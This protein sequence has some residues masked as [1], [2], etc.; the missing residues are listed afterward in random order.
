MKNKH[1]I[2]G[3]QEFV[4]WTTIGNIFAK[5]LCPNEDIL[6]QYNSLT[7]SQRIKIKQLFSQCDDIRRKKIPADEVSFTWE[8]GIMVDAHI[9]ACEYDIDP[10][11]AV[12]CINPICKPNEKLFI[13]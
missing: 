11:T 6:K 9:I 5:S 2:K 4:K 12:L 1:V 7:A 10:L 8:I 13:K 3:K